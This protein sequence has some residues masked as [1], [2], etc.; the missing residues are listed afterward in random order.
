M[1]SRACRDRWSTESL[2]PTKR[3]S[4]GRLLIGVVGFLGGFIGPIYLSDSNL[5]PPA[6]LRH[7][8]RWRFCRGVC[9]RSEVRQI[10]S[11]ILH[12]DHRRMVLCRVAAGTSLYVLHGE[13]G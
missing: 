8:A 10:R 11:T 3:L 5:G 4:G 6:W 2:A 1:P 13:S 7:G 9:G 12:A